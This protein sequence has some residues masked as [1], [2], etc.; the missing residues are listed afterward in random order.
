V[1]SYNSKRT[2]ERSYLHEV[3]QLRVEEKK[4]INISVSFSFGQFKD[5]PDKNLPAIFA[6]VGVHILLQRK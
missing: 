5:I 2:S 1:L 4:K 3:L 6:T